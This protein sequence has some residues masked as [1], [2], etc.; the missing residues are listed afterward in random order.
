MK[1]GVKLDTWQKKSGFRRSE[2]VQKDDRYGQ[3][4]YFCINNVDIFC[5]GSCWIPADNFLPRATPDVYRSWLKLMI[6]GNQIMTRYAPLS[7][8]NCVVFK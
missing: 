5:G 2:L 4:F 8:F 3:S 1:E 6:E 7:Y